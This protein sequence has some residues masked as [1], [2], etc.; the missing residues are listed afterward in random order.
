M[1]AN[2]EKFILLLK[3]LTGISFMNIHL[4]IFN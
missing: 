3:L 2:I 4:Q 1:I